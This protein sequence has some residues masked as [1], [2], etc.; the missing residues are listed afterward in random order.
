MPRLNNVAR[1]AARLL[2]RCVTALRY[3]RRLNYS[4]HLA[5]I[6]AERA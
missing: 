5:W 4:R 2:A 1:G 6:K 3:M